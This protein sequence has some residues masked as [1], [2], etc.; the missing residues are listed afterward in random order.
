MWHVLTVQYAAVLLA[1]CQCRLAQAPS[2]VFSGD[3]L[4]TDVTCWTSYSLP[5]AATKPFTCER[6]T[7]P[8]MNMNVSLPL[9][10]K[11]VSAVKKQA[12]YSRYSKSSST[13]NHFQILP[14]ERA[15]QKVMISCLAWSFVIRD[16][17]CTSTSTFLLL[18]SQSSQTSADAHSHARTHAHMFSSTISF[19]EIHPHSK[20]VV[21]ICF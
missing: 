17:Y 9:K 10:Q 13:N 20:A 12:R 3:H 19:N 16:T 21:I 1:V 2:V 18:S 6:I 11:H 14:G 8:K 7:F 15:M 4:W 5:N